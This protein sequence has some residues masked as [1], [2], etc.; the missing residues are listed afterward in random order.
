MIERELM[1]FEKKKRKLEIDILK[2]A[3]QLLDCN[4]EQY[5]LMSNVFCI[6]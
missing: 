5:L 3:L 6:E 4:L 1:L 2:N